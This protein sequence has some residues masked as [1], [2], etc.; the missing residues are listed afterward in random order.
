[1]QLIMKNIKYLSFIWF[2]VVFVL[3]IGCVE[4]ID[5]KTISFEDALVVEGTITNELKFHQIKLSRTFKL[6]ESI[7]ATESNAIVQVIDDLQ[8]TY[9]FQEER[10]GVY[11]S[12]T[13]FKAMPSRQ[14]QLRITTSN[15]RSYASHPTEITPEAQ[16]NDVI[17]VKEFNSNGTEGISIQVSSF[18]SNGNARYYRY[19]FEETY[20]IVPPYWS[21]YDAVVVS[22]VAP[23]EVDF[24]PRTKEERVCYNTIFSEGIIQT[25][26]NNLVEDKVSKFPVR[27][28]SKDNFII[29][30]RYSILVKQ[31]VQSLEAYSFYN[32]L[33]TQ[34]IS[35]GVFS[36]TQPGFLVGNVFSETNSNEKVVGFFEVA[37]MDAQRVFFNY[38]DLFPNEDLPPYF[39][40]CDDFFTPDILSVDMLTGAWTGSP[41][42]RA[43]D[44]GFQFYDRDADPPYRL[45][46]D[47]CG[48]CTNLGNN[49]VPDFWED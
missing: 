44:D 33:S 29:T 28:I 13:E 9:N 35:E 26:T 4:Q 5:L 39:M 32:A 21:P 11:L 49:N 6:E 22:D 8:N 43:L 16:I 41:L 48:D 34:S 3:T 37:S 15:G 20:K 18:N 40:E 45:V 36:E 31:Y 24:V 42:V 12:E 30:N 17:A 46:F 10:P 14:Y 23:F 38:A 1:M 19:E 25:E 47:V 27:F 7:P 2:S